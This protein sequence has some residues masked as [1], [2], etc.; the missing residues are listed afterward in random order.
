MVDW[1]YW[2]KF[3]HYFVCWAFSFSFNHFGLSCI[4]AL[5]PPGN[6]GPHRDAGW[7]HRSWDCA[8]RRIRFLLPPQTDCLK[9]LNEDFEIWTQLK[10]KRQ[11]ILGEDREFTSSSVSPIC[12]FQRRVCRWQSD[13]IVLFVRNGS[14]SK[15]GSFKIQHYICILCFKGKYNTLIR[16]FIETI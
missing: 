6:G 1:R 11:I 7:W 9:F 14:R 16:K 10:K 13:V 2:L 12:L 5:S 4:L 15:S 8:S 3:F